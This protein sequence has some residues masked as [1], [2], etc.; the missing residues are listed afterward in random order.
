[1]SCIDE[2]IVRFF[3]HMASLS[4][5]IDDYEQWMADYEKNRYKYPDWVTKNGRHIPISKL[6]DKHL[7]NLIPFVQRKDPKNETRWADLLKHEQL[8]RELLV[9][10]PKMRADLKNM[11]EI[12]EQ[13]L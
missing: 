1:M 13:C 5:G 10:V 8:Y 12:S 2:E 9:K 3:D 7:A 4:W 6:D 11:R